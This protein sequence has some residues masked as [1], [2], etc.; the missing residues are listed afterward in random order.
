[1]SVTED[2][3]TTQIM[4]RLQL[5]EGGMIGVLLASQSLILSSMTSAGEMTGATD[6]HTGIRLCNAAP[7][8]TSS[9]WCKAHLF[10]Q[11]G[12]VPNV[13]G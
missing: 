1:M 11:L 10:V 8:C 7:S 9:C 2:Q 3:S 4:T 12:L 6:R 5:T 13:F